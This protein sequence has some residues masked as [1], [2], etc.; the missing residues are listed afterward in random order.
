MATFNASPGR[1][2][3]LAQP[4]FLP[5][6]AGNGRRF[7]L[8]VAALVAVVAGVLYAVLY[9]LVATAGWLSPE[10]ARL[11][12]PGLESRL[13][14]VNSSAAGPMILALAACGAATFA[15]YRG[16]LAAEGCWRP[17]VM[18]AVIALVLAGLN[19]VNVTISYVARD[20]ENALVGYDEPSFYGVLGVY[21]LCLAVALPIRGVQRFVTPSLGLMWREWLSA[22]LL[23][24]YLAEKRYYLLSLS[25]DLALDNP[26]QRISDD[27][28]T[29]CA[30]SL[31]FSVELLYSLMN[32]GSFALVLWSIS[33]SLML[34]LLVYAAIGSLG[35]TLASQK[36]ASHYL[37]SLPPPTQIYFPLVHI[38]LELQF[39]L[40]IFTFTA[41]LSST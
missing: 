37:F 18:L 3:K 31:A 30:T 14:S 40:P 10:T 25:A 26:D 1:F 32:F 13:A 34:A 11:L 39:T 4:F 41:T 15:H 8:L 21:A 23:A 27:V 22:R 35:I 36:L 7:A 38:S 5:L 19:S 28:Q 9:I 33:P 2:L 29:F 24:G 6:H 17:W 12:L 20:V 16:P